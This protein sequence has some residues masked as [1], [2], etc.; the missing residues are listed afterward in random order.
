M[1]RTGAERQ[2]R[3]RLRH[4]QATKQHLAERPR[5]HSRGQGSNADGA[6]PPSTP[7]STPTDYAVEANASA[8]L[9]PATMRNRALALQTLRFI[10]LG[11]DPIVYSTAIRYATPDTVWTLCKAAQQAVGNTHIHLSDYEIA[12]LQKYKEHIITL[13]SPDI[14]IE[15]KRTILVQPMQDNDQIAE[16]VN[17][18]PLVASVAVHR[19]DIIRAIALAHRRQGEI[20]GDDAAQV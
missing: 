18:V 19:P 6:A 16:S 13:A 14:P 8:C 9:T 1:D 2:R 20:G 5:G 17:Y 11:P 7:P 3:W 10:A 15:T 4:K 12:V